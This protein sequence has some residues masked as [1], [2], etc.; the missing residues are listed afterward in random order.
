M[1]RIIRRFGTK[2]ILGLLFSLLAMESLAQSNSPSTTNFAGNWDVILHVR[3]IGSVHTILT[4]EPKSEGKWWAYSRPGALRDAVGWRKAF[5]ALLFSRDYPKGSF[6]HIDDGTTIQHNDT[7]QVAGVISAPVWGKLRMNGFVVGNKWKGTLFSLRTGKP[8]ALIEG[9]PFQ[10]QPPLCNYPKILDTML[11][12]TQIHYYRPS[13]LN[14]EKWNI[15][16]TT[17]RE[18]FGTAQDD[19][20]AIIGCYLSLQKLQT[21]HYGLYR[22]LDVTLPE[23]TDEENPLESAPIRFSINDKSIGI[24]TV[25]SF[26]FGDDPIDSVFTII[27]QQK[28]TSLII[29]L[30]NNPGGTLLSMAVAG[31]LL[32]KPEPAGT[33]IG[34]KW[35]KSH[36]RLPTAADIAQLPLLTETDIDTFFVLL[37]KY[38]GLRGEVTP[39]H[40]IYNGKAAVLING[41][42]ASACEPLAYLLQSTGRAKI[43]GENS[44]GAMLSSEG[45]D[46]GQGWEVLVPTADYYTADGKRLEGTG[47]KPDIAVKS[48]RAM[49]TAIKWL[50]DNR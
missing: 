39:D 25:K 28:P 37:R 11:A 36:D 3:D 46:I 50:V 48:D 21:S 4:I 44:A 10:S 35:W 20:D 8:Y 13:E 14:D 27:N 40:T 12:T 26:G 47:V 5:L 9:V 23:I 2:I 41:N 31:H 22:K 29:D 17:L 7:L 16:R 34:V 30:R 18:K 49:D 43:I 33:F 38:G 6:I 24:L 15:L 19:I 1:S 42:T 45:F 32:D